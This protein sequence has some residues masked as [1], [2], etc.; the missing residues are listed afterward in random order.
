MLLLVSIHMV[1]DEYIDITPMYKMK[2]GWRISDH[3]SGR[4]SANQKVPLNFF[5]L[6]IQLELE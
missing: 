5:F 3:F 4:H 2:V 6:S 1:N